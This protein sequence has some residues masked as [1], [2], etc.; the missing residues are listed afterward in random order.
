M[1]LPSFLTE[2]SNVYNN[3]FAPLGFIMVGE[4]ILYLSLPLSFKFPH[5]LL[6][7]KIS[8]SSRIFPPKLTDFFVSLLKIILR[9]QSF[10]THL[11][12]SLEV[13]SQKQRK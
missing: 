9:L 7:F 6:F 1:P 10:P 2:F 4:L 12:Y 5:S 8:I 13:P 3:F 11:F